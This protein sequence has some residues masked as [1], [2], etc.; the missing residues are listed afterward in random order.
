MLLLPCREDMI[1]YLH[2][3]GYL[4]GVLMLCIIIKTNPFTLPYPT[5]G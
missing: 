5:V 3:T 1:F 4:S 2:V